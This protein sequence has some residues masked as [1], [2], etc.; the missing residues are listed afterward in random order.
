MAACVSPSN[1]GGFPEADVSVGDAELR[2][3]VADEPAERSQGL[4]GVS[5][6]PGDIDG[7]LFVFTRPSVP[8]FVMEDTRLALD[9]W[10]FDPGGVLIAKEEM[11][12]CSNDPCPRYPA[13]AE[14]SWALETPG[15][16]FQFEEGD[17]LST[18][19][20]G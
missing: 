9:L 12:P 3:W 7:M 15:G 13:P 18:S 6:L 5:R 11:E 17:R 20:S 1:Q 8:T 2:V 19:G 14:V 4:R 10:F 16:S